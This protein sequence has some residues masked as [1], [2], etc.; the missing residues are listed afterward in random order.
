MSTEVLLIDAKG[1]RGLVGQALLCDGHVVEARR[2]SPRPAA[3]GNLL[4]SA[5]RLASEMGAGPVIER[6]LFPPSE[7]WTWPALLDANAFRIVSTQGENVAVMRRMA[8]LPVKATLEI[9]QE[10]YGTLLRLTAR[11]GKTM[12]GIVGALAYFEEAIDEH[13][14][15]SGHGQAFFER[16]IELMEEAESKRLELGSQRKSPGPRM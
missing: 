14:G 12:S 7:A 11:H 8:G 16:C 15:E 5:Q 2:F 10:S 6:T 13:Y 3:P 1:P 9:P 4:A